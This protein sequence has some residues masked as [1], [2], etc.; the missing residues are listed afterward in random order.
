MSTRLPWM[1]VERAS[2]SASSRAAAAS[3]RSD[4][5]WFGL[6]PSA[7]A[8]ALGRGSE[9]VRRLAILTE[10]YLIGDQSLM[11]APHPKRVRHVVTHF[12]FV[13]SVGTV[14]FK[15]GRE[16]TD[17]SGSARQKITRVPRSS[18]SFKLGIVTRIRWL[19]PATVVAV[20]GIAL[21]IPGVLGL[22]S[23]FRSND[24]HLAIET[25]ATL[26]AVLVG[27]LLYGRLRDTG[28]RR[29]LLL[30]TA[31]GAM[32]LT[33]LGAVIAPSFDGA[34]NEVIWAPVSARLIAVA[35]L[36]AAVIAPETRLRHPSRRLAYACLGIAGVAA[37]VTVVALA[38]TGLSAGVNP[39]HSSDITERMFSGSGLFI[40]AQLACVALFLT[41]ALG[42]AH[43]A[44]RSEDPLLAWLAIGAGLAAIARLDYL[45]FPSAAS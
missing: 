11:N 35:I 19:L 4:R 25:T 9:A 20:T 21:V 45:V 29:D 43:R 22:G 30:F 7:E 16:F 12:A 18:A 3:G 34:N 38:S 10:T 41:A 24:A 32:A 17:A 42:F 37:I 44:E 13:S 27:F 40:A 33:N 5:R 36:A 15:T 14:E 6:V 1:K 39:A 8:A 2:S 31:L 26:V 23:G 28:L